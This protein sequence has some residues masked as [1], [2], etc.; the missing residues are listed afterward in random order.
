[1]PIII[2]I[3]FDLQLQILFENEQK[4]HFPIIVIIICVLIIETRLNKS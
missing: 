3:K 1:M 2:S 4:V